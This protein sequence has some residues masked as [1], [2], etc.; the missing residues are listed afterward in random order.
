MAGCVRVLIDKDGKVK[1][2]GYGFQGGECDKIMDELLS[3]IG[4]VKQSARKRPERAG[5]HVRQQE[6]E[7]ER[8][9]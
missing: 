9:S 8:Q 4:R 3:E 7:K 6:R 1:G 2:E 5:D